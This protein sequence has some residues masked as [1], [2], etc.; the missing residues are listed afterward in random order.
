MIYNK[1]M[2][3]VV[4]LLSLLLF[5]SGCQSKGQDN[6]RSIPC[7]MS[8]YT[9]LNEEQQG[10]F[11]EIDV[12]SL[13][14]IIEKKKSAVI[15]F[16]YPDCDNCQKMVY[17]MAIIAKE[18]DMTIYYLNAWKMCTDSDESYLKGLYL[19]DPVLEDSDEMEGKAII[20]PELIRIEKGE[21]TDWYIG[22]DSDVDERYREILNV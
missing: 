6:I 20:C 10:L 5:M 1:Y 16:G 9:E 8:V 14:D 22:Y 15:Y 17:K 12:D 18:Y 19:L 21:Y 13:A 11:K 3:K 7:D 2:R 4:V